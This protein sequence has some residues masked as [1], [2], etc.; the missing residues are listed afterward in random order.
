[1]DVFY[2]ILYFLLWVVTFIIYWRRKRN[3]DA[4]WIIILSYLIS[5]G[6]AIW[7]YLSPA[8]YYDFEPLRFFP[9]VYLFLMLLLAL[10]PV[11]RF[12]SKQIT[13]IEQP[14]M[15]VLNATACF[16]IFFSILYI[17]ALY[18]L[19]QGGGLTQ[20]LS[21]SEA[22]QEMY[23]ETISAAGDSGSGIENIP[24]IVV[25]AFSDIVIFLLFYYLSLPK[26]YWGL[27]VG[28]FMSS[29]FYLLTPLFNG[30]RGG[31]VIAIFT[32]V[33][34][35]FLMRSYYSA[36]LRKWMDRAGLILIAMVIIPIAAITISRFGEENGGSMS[37]VVYYAGQ[38]PLNFNNYGLDAGGI[39]NG[40]RTLNLVKQMIDSDTPKNYVERRDK[41]YYLKMD[42]NIFYTFVGDFTLDFGP[43]IAPLIFLLFTGLIMRLTKP[44][45]NSIAFHQLLLIYF[46][47][48]I[49][50]QGSFYLFAYADT[51]G[52]KIVV[53]FILYFVFKYV[54]N[55]TTTKES[56]S[57]C[58]D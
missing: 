20:L 22:G 31:V 3:L 44:K 51:A 38:A 46:V 10:S 55:K 45:E 12:D 35:Y 43:Y 4:G 14:N 58:Q 19:F 40:D 50:M 25:N 33:A 28:L 18:K 39:R 9:F 16:I 24:S 23:S 29:V 26:K 37:S 30:L 53:L 32:F 49:C 56:V 1:M 13:S 11:I 54:P 36:R 2:L 52:L 42:D 7:L 6:F 41:Y 34:A 47:V 8:V 17:P 15:F 48:C 27:I 5:A 57:L 21:D